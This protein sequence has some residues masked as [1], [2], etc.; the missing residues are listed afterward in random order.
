[1]LSNYPTL[2]LA[3]IDRVI[4]K[5]IWQACLYLQ[6]CQHHGTTPPPPGKESWKV[7]SE[8]ERWSD[9]SDRIIPVSARHSETTI[10]MS[11]N[12]EC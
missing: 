3:L 5:I 7:K 10:L 12:D 2:Y 8:G 11:E 9:I 1:M 4:V 6:H